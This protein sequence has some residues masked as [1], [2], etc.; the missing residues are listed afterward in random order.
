MLIC[1][2][3]CA[4]SD[5]GSGWLIKTQVIFLLFEVTPYHYMS[6]KHLERYVD[7]FAFR[8]N[9]RKIDNFILL[10]NT[11]E[12][13]NNRISYKELTGKDLICG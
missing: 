5:R 3:L 1:A 11:V 9:N 4:S 2:N 12:N 13:M 10:S 8:Y 7:E 6:K